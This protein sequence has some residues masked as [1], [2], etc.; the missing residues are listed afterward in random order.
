MKKIFLISFFLFIF[1]ALL[2]KNYQI[3]NIAYLEWDE[4]MYAQIAKEIIKNKSLITTFNDNLWFDK[5][6]LSHFLIALSFLIFGENEFT[7]R[8]TMVIL[9]LILLFLFYKLNQKLTK[10]IFNNRKKHLAIILPIIILIAT[11]IFLERATTLN[12]DLL[13]AISWLGYLTFFKNSFA[14]ILFILIGVWGKSVLGFYPLLYDFFLLI[15]KKQKLNFSYIKNTLTAIFLASFWYI[16][17]FIKYGYFFIENHFLSQ[18]FKRIYVPIE[19]HF[20]NKFFYFEVLWKN[21]YLLLILITISYLIII[22]DFVKKIKEK[23]KN[24]DIYLVYFFSLPFFSFLTLMKTKIEWYVIIFLPFLLLP[25]TYFLYRTK[26]KAF[27]FLIIFFIGFFSLKNFVQQTFL[28]KPTKETNEKVI[29]AKC[30]SRINKNK[31][32]FLVDEQE[33]KNRNFLEAAH[34]QT[35]SSFFYGGTPSFVYYVK[36]PVTFFYSQKEF[37]Q[38][39]NKNDVIYVINKNDKSIINF[40]IKKTICQTKNWLSF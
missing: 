1:F 5:P 26:N 6:P 35:T 19:L 38:N 27:Y 40:D 8:A 3:R 12:S 14:R 31:V 21:L 13:V 39:L 17:L 20:G 15:F 11:P 22:F 9:S 29:L 10:K 28:L 34:Y 32:F 24:I 33:R 36:K 2:V 16:F 7:S 23:S 37:Q 4:G 30:I 18:M 25:I